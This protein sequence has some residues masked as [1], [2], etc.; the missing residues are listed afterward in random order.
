MKFFSL[1]VLESFNRFLNLVVGVAAITG[2]AGMFDYFSQH[3][4]V[5]YD[6]MSPTTSRTVWINESAL[7][8]YYWE[9]NHKIPE[10]VMKHIQR[11]GK[12]VLP[13]LEAAEAGRFDPYPKY[14]Y[15][16]LEK[17][18]RLQSYERFLTSWGGGYP[19]NCDEWIDHILPEVTKLS[20]TE[21]RALEL[22]ILSAR[23]VESTISLK[24]DGDLLAK[25]IK[26][27]I[28]AVPNLASGAKGSILSIMSAMPIP[29]PRIYDYRAEFHMPFLQPKH[30]NTVKVIT[31]EAPIFRK[32]I[33]VD[34]ETQRVVR[35]GKLAA[36]FLILLG[37]SVA[38]VMVFSRL[39]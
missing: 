17:K 27:Y 13:E 23:R 18:L 29:K 5:T 15:S 35:S 39:S 8:S 11:D 6:L 24:N 12:L 36:V 30:G 9:H 7:M 22:A 20:Q 19:S 28:I 25:N 37:L 32:N 34:Y 31:R 38:T 21:Q 3:A 4:V 16:N 10:P 14:E 1:L 26:V 33:G 2:L